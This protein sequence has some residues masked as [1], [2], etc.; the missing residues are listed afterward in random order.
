MCINARVAELEAILRHFVQT[1]PA[2]GG[3]AAPKD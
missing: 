1:H 2:A 3:P